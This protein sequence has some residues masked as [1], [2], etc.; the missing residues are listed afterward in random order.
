MI[1]ENCGEI[2][3][4]AGGW[5]RSPQERGVRRDNVRRRGE[6]SHCQQVKG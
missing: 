6:A 4:I 5:G 1:E 3:T 2:L